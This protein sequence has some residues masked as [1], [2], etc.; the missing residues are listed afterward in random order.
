ME[1]E[2][3]NLIS[4]QFQNQ[5]P[6]KQYSIDEAIKEFEELNQREK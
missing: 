3:N 2:N 1:N 4:Y 5:L 6:K